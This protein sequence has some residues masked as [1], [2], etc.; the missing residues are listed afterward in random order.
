MGLGKNVCVGYSTVGVHV[1]QEGPEVERAGEAEGRVGM[2]VVGGAAAAAAGVGD[3]TVG[4]GDAG[5][6]QRRGGG[7]WWA[8]PS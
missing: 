4:L 1:R 5:R 8:A 3:A 6:G 2:E 7:L